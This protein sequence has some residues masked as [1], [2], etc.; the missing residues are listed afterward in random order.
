MESI[1]DSDVE[2]DTE[3]DIMGDIDDLM[4]KKIPKVKS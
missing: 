2:L 3:K 4:G 1:E